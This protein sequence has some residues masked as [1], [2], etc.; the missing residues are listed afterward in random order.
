MGFY[1]Y[2]EE[3]DVIEGERDPVDYMPERWNGMLQWGLSQL[4]SRPQLD[5]D[6]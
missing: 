5:G 1:T 4:L 6:E 2:D 3:I